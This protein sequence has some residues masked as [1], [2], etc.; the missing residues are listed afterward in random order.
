M[1]QE[2]QAMASQQQ[3]H[4]D[5][6]NPDS[7]NQNSSQE[8]PMSEPEQSPG[9]EPAS[10]LIQADLVIRNIGQLVT[11][12]QSPI[13]G[14]EGRLQI[15]PNG[16]IAAHMGRI[17]WIGPE[18][19]LEQAVDARHADLIDA[20]GH[21]ATPGFV[22]SHTHLIFAG[23]RAQ[24]FHLRHQGVSYAELAAQGR[25]ILSTVRATRAASPEALTNLAHQRLERF[26]ACGTTTL[27]AKTG[28]GLNL[29]TE[30]TCLRILN[31]L[32]NNP[33]IQP[34]I[35]T[36]LGAHT[37]PP[38]YKDRRE[39]YVDLVV[40]EMLPAFAGHARFCDVFCEKSAFTLEES[41]RILSRARELGYLLKIHAEQLSPSGGAR[42]A[43]ELG[44]TSADHLDYA[45]GDDLDALREAGVIATLL[46]GCSF[47][48]STPYPS[49]RPLLDRGLIVALA[50]DYNPGTSYC[51]N[52][53]MM[54]DLGISAMGMTLEEA[55]EAT[56]INGARA[57]AFADEAGSLEVGKR[58]DLILW[59]MRDYHEL[60]Y[61][62]G[63][64]LVDQVFIAGIH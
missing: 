54:L 62:F 37:L 12:A 33:L 31:E 29:E 36:F 49:A 21:T 61:H 42:L 44:A 1:Q 8:N 56:T 58:C 35:P 9:T 46:P 47:T 64:N 39:A 59:D 24:E 4:P 2:V 50:T 51:E 52:M 60:G 19:L 10:A 55:L 38:E 16:A 17:V 40:E 57:L 34:L 22:D 11:V 30:A 5:S 41:Q 13:L 53:Q 15:I 32:N 23:N 48:L 3:S 28:Y 63:V 45:S 18:H 27:E 43:A 7:S 6:S 26:R 25:G 20:E 14:A